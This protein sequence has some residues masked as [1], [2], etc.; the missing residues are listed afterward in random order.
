MDGVSPPLMDW[1]VSSLPE[2]WRKFKLHV[3]LM[4]SGPPE[5][6]IGGGK[7]Q[8]S[9]ALGRRKRT[10]H[11][12]YMDSVRRGKDAVGNVLQSF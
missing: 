5:E 2:A 8:L 1:D 3:K 7:M 10:G 6:E 11:L 9:S 4:F 12:Q